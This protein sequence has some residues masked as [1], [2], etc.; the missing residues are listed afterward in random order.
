MQRKEK[1][2]YIK[3]GYE[4]E[5]MPFFLYEYSIYKYTKNGVELLYTK[6]YKSNKPIKV[7]EPIYEKRPKKDTR[8]YFYAR[9]VDWLGAPMSYI[10]ENG[11][12]KVEY[13]TNSRKSKKGTRKGSSKS[14]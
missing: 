14:K 12:K 1:I 9:F 6:M 11:F 3:N 10:N 7:P 13:G 5:P 4:V 8:G 2:S